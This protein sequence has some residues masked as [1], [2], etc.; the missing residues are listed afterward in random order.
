MIGY[1]ATFHYL[2]DKGYTNI[3]LLF[4]A[5]DVIAV[6]IPTLLP[7]V[8]SITTIYSISRLKKEKIFCIAPARI[9]VSG[10]VKIMVFDKT[11]TLTED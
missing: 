11:G 1:C 6:S 8:I 4:A 10:R 7:I 2:V 3:E 5:F 9:C